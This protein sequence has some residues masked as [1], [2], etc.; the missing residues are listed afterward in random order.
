M[1]TH[2]NIT[3]SQASARRS[4]LSYI[5]IGN[6]SL[7][8]SGASRAAQFMLLEQAFKEAGLDLSQPVVCTCGTGTT[9]CILLLAMQQ[10]PAPPPAGPPSQQA[11]PPPAWLPAPAVRWQR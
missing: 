5:I 3:L 9:A 10:L 11:P 4:C 7:G 8:Q 1:H 2:V 6:N